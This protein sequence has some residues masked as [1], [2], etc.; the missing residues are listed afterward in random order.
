MAHQTS[1]DATPC[2]L[3][4]FLLFG[5]MAGGRVARRARGYGNTLRPPG[6]GAWPSETYRVAKRRPPMGNPSF[7]SPYV[8]GNRPMGNIP[9]HGRGRI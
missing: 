2:F 4:L 1:V 7:F 9:P 6:Y 5:G 3:P 8:M